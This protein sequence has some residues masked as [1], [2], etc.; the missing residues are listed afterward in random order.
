MSHTFR[1]DT[2]SFDPS[3]ITAK[4][5]P[6]ILISNFCSLYV[7]MM[8]L[9]RNSQ[10]FRIFLFYF[11]Q[12]TSYSIS[13]IFSFTVIIFLITK[14]INYIF[15]VYNNFIIIFS[16]YYFGIFCVSFNIFY[17]FIIFFILFF[18]FYNYINFIF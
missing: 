8:Q 1:L 9:F 7:F 13:F 5:F 3:S 12:F 18:I 10:T 6:L 2:C 11:I 15:F 17:K 4:I 14:I 16:Y